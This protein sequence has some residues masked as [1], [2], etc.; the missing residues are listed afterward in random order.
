M[1][2]PFYGK[3]PRHIFFTEE[4]NLE[5]K[6]SVYS[7]QE[8]DNEAAKRIYAE[9]E[10]YL[11]RREYDLALP[12]Y[13]SLS[14]TRFLSAMCL[15]RIAE[16]ANVLCDARYASTCFYKAF[17][18]E[19]YLNKRL[20]PKENPLHMHVYE[21]M[22]NRRW[23]SCPLCGG[24]G[25]PLWCY[26]IAIRSNCPKYFNPIKTWLYCKACH[27]LWTAEATEY[28]EVEAPLLH[29]SVETKVNRL[30]F[31]TYSRILNMLRK[32][33]QGS[34]LLE[35]GVGKGECIAVARELLYD[36]TGIDITK[37]CVDYVNETFHMNVIH[38][39]FMAYPFERLFDVI[40]M[41]DVVEHVR[42]PR[43]FIKKAAE[44]SHS[45]TVLWVSTPSFESV[46]TLA[47]GHDDPMRRE[48]SHCG[49]FS[50]SSLC[51]ILNTYGFEIANYEISANYYGS[52]EVTAIKR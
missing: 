15:F 13:H 10:G 9:A 41:G 22:D 1:T 37:A 42:D 12:L 29:S 6:A 4:Y 30:L 32:Y 33:A 38:G 2:A 3:S 43:S 14:G 31:P 11:W 17:E 21:Q 44:H 46:Y 52:M 50:Y 45:G 34:A 7:L 47:A 23:E 5:C 35:V 48:P 27:H 28:D 16:I 20:L 26:Y 39:D 8:Y 51:G 49:Y 36:V 40:I 19:P 18:V 25:R 24:A